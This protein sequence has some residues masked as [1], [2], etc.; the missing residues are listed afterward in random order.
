MTALPNMK[1]FFIFVV[2]I[3]AG[4]N[5][6]TNCY[7]I[8][9]SCAKNSTDACK[10]IHEKFLQTNATNATTWEEISAC[11]RS[12]PYDLNV[13]KETIETLKG[14]FGSFYP[15]LDEAKEEPKPGFTFK[16]INLTVELDRLLEKKY[17]TEIE[18]F[19][20]AASVINSLS[21]AHSQ[22]LSYCYEIFLFDQKLSLY[23][24]VRDGKQIIEVF[25]DSVDPSNVNC[26]VVSIDG[27]PA[28]DVITQFALKN[29]GWARDLGGGVLQAS[30][31]SELFTRRGQLP[32][33]PYISYTLNCGG[34]HLKQVNRSWTVETGREVLANFTDSESYRKKFCLKHNS[35]DNGTNSGFF[36][37]SAVH[38]RRSKRKIDVPSLSEGELI[39]DAIIA[40]FYI[41]R[42]VGVAVISTEDVSTFNKTQIYTVLINLNEGFRSFAKRKIE[43]VVLDLSNNGGGT[44]AV[45]QYIVLLLFP[46]ITPSFPYDERLTDLYRLA[47]EIT[48]ANLSLTSGAPFNYH[49]Y[50]TTENNQNFTSIQQFFG[51]NLFTRGGVQDSYSSKFFLNLESTL[52]EI[53]VE[54]QGPNAPP[55][56]WTRDNIIIL[57]NGFCGS[58]CANLAQLLVE[59]KQIKTVAV[60]G[61]LS[62]EQLSYSSFLGGFV[63]TSDWI[64]ATLNQVGLNHS[65]NSLVPKDFFLWMFAT[66]P[67]NEVYSSIL[68]DT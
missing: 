66:L 6:I 10:L 58:A 44:I 53:L 30:E 13:A 1:R 32:P 63:F 23:S 14:L 9:P 29:I 68:N 57:T 45:L 28:L 25:D 61:L 56:N 51:N 26:E 7:N 17:E 31:Y 43:K 11:F 18:F 62:Q 60:G 20:D 8:P 19:T 24:I 39:V 37:K 27:L 5:S 42:D 65:S 4:I 12:F 3:L 59:K 48:S 36:T 2:V 47:T 41:V 50:V 16:P 52:R 54:V 55:L 38:T 34:N 21:D 35:A 67:L 49:E 15:F 22:L 64:F 33:T 40:R 46:D